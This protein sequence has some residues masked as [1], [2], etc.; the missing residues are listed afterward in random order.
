MKICTCIGL[1][2]VIGFAVV[3]CR[4]GAARRV[5]EYEDGKCCALAANLCSI[6]SA[7]S[8]Y[9]VHYVDEWPVTQK[10]AARNRSADTRRCRVLYSTCVL[11]LV[12]VLKDVAA[13][14]SISFL[15]YA[16]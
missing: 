13:V 2:V 16:M 11:V 1:W 3:S 9:C 15:Q 14:L 4:A 6:V 5:N 12:P 8:R 10:N 7:A